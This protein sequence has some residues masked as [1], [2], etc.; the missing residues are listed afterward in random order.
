MAGSNPP[1]DHRERVSCF[2]NDLVG[3]RMRRDGGMVAVDDVAFPAAGFE[4]IEGQVG[5]G[6]ECQPHDF[7]RQAVMARY[8]GMPVAGTSDRHFR[9]L[10]CGVVGSGKAAVVR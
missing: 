3:F 10:Q 8:R 9:G 7:K 2:E 1:F 4:K 6:T 5:G